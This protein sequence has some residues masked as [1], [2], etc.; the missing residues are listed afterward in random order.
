[1]TRGGKRSG[2]GRPTGT[3]QYG[4]QTKPVRVPVSKIDAVKEFILSESEAPTIPL[5]GSDVQAGAPDLGDDYVEAHVNLHD[6]VVERPQA[7]FFVRAKGQ[8]MKNAGIGDGDLMVVDRDIQAKNGHIIVAAVDGELTVKRLH[9]TAT[10]L[11][12]LPENE[13]FEPIVV[14]QEQEFTVWG[15]VTNV[16]HRL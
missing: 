12:L 15:V 6:Y 8:S 9:K 11:Q 10:S 5:F 3:G 16:I 7:T 13:D 2:A 4:E 14:Q 1:M